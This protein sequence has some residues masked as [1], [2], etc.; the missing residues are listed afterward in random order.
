[1]LDDF[2]VEQP[3]A[4]QILLNSL[5]YNR[6]SHAYLF[7]TRN[8]YN[9]DKLALAFA[10]YLLCSEHH[11]SQEEAKDCSICKRI[12]DGNFTELKIIE[13]DGNWIKKEQIDEL[14]KMFSTKAV[15]SERKVYIIKEAE[16]MNSS[17]A[18]SILKFLEEPEDNIIAILLTDNIYQLLNTIISR[19][20]VISLREVQHKETNDTLETIAN[21]ICNNSQ[22]VLDF[23][24]NYKENDKLDII[25]KFVL[26]YELNHLDILLDIK[27]RWY[28]YFSDRNTVGQALLILILFYKDLLNLKFDLKLEY[29]KEYKEQLLKIVDKLTKDEIYVTIEIILKHYKDLNFNANINLLMDKLIIDLERRRNNG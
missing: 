2:K 18:N 4:Y 24:T 29:F 11:T 23:V 21:I 27:N 20:Q 10:K 9:K 1:M 12:D 3:I 26:E 17:A 6:C 8:Y 22:D 15:E 13:P 16:K 19:C 14:Q 28:D 7:E 25:I 5:K